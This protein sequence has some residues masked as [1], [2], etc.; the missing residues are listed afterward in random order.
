[1]QTRFRQIFR[2]KFLKKMSTIANYLK[3]VLELLHTT[4]EH[5]FLECYITEQWDPFASSQTPSVKKKK[6]RGEKNRKVRGLM[7]GK[8][9][10]AAS[11]YTFYTGNVIIN[12]SML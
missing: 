1:M 2:M 11:P 7:W 6:K 4:T 12:K 5:L 8:T 3:P 10:S 9:P